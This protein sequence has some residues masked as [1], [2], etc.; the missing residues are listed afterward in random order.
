MVT[1]KG[2][3]MTNKGEQVTLYTI[4]SGKASASIC[5][6]GATLVNFFVPDKNGVMTDIVLGFDDAAGYDNDRATYFGATV[7]RF[8]NRI[9][10]GKFTLNG[11]EYTLPQNNN[12]KNCLHGGIDGFSF[13]MYD[14]EIGDN[15]VEMS[16]L[17]KDGE[18][19]FP[20][21]L[22]FKVRYT[23]VDTDLSIEYFAVCDADTVMGFTNHSYFNLNG[24]TSGESILNHT[25][26]INAEAF[27]VVDSDGLFT[28]QI[29]PVEGTV[30]DFRKPSLL[31]DKL[32]SNDPSIAHTGYGIDNF[33]PNR[34]ERNGMYFNSS[35]YAADN[36]IKLDCYTDQIGVQ[37]YTS[38]FIDCY[39]KKGTKHGKY[40]AVCLETQGYPDAPNI[41][42]VPSAV[43]RAGEEYYTKTVYK[44]S[45][46]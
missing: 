34:N 39:G 42:Y 16:I 8:G 2:F 9:K 26:M 19:G 1:T 45:V 43:L 31:G 4:D 10:G 15:F 6:F 12:G 30:Y 18:E 46:E 32:L 21:N 44:A 27:G 14:A 41:P 38:A 20:G 40:A 28:G 24:A 33:F 37:V 17:S 23:L 25:L 3:G 35:I 36:G 13:R 11:K 5:D 22:K 29:T 7:G